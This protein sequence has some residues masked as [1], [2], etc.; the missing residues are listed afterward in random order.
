MKEEQLPPEYYQGR[1][2]P[3]GANN[4]Y[5]NGQLKQKMWWFAGY[6]DAELFGERD[7]TQRDQFENV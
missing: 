4:P 5:G 3:D 2:A 1:T 7:G 6:D